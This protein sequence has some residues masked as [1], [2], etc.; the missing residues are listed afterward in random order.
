LHQWKKTPFFSCPTAANSL[1]ELEAGS[2]WKR[3]PVAS[4]TA[5]HS[6]DA[7]LI[8]ESNENRKRLSLAGTI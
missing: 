1:C 2:D 4:F 3:V 8:T 5:D 6:I 7:L